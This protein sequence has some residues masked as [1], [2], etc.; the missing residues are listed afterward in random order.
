MADVDTSSLIG[1]L[2]AAATA[3]TSVGIVIREYLKREK[4]SDASDTS[5]VKGFKGNDAVLDNLVSEVARLSIRITDL[6]SKVDHL[7]EKLANVR[8]IA[9]D[10]YQLAT[11]CNCDHRERLLDHLKQIIKDA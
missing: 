5:K 8:L 11:D 9:L 2:G 10:C 4:V 7:T 6:E 3:I 1:Y